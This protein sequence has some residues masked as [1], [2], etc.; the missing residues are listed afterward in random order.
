MKNALII[1]TNEQIQVIT[2]RIQYYIQSYIDTLEDPNDIYKTFTFSG[3][4]SYIAYNVF[5][6]TN[7]QSDYDGSSIIDYNDISTL[8][9]IWNIYKY[10][11]ARYN[12]SYSLQSFSLFTGIHY[13]SIK[14]WKNNAND[15]RHSIVNK[16]FSECESMLLDRTVNDNSVGSLFVLK[17]LYSYRDN[18]N[19][20]NIYIDNSTNRLTAEQI[21]DKYGSISK[22][23]ALPELDS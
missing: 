18:D 14:N 4:L 6:N 1:N 22:P 9:N 2:D 15:S 23:D 7:K 11:C 3:L 10:I 5:R 8:E 12:K 16:W 17:A 13:E 21:A 19:N 20:T